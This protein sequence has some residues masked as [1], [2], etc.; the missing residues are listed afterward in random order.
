MR[1]RFT[2]PLWQWQA[3]DGWYFVTLPADVADEIADGIADLDRAPSGFG[4]VRVRVTVGRTTWD[5]SVFPDATLGSYVLPVKKA[6]RNAESLTEG[7]D[8]DVHLEVL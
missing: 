2:A 5:T 1:R 3:R 8:V 4:A 6:V 7:S